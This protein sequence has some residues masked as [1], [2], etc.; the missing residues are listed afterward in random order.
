M[1]GHPCR[2]SSD[3]DDALP[4]IL[5]LASDHQ[6]S[7]VI[8]QTL[9]EA[10][11]SV[12]ST[13][14]FQR[15]AGGALVQ[16]GVQSA[17]T[18]EFTGLY[19]K[20]TDQGLHPLVVKGAVIRELYPRGSLRPSIDEDLL[21]REEEAEACSA[22]LV[23]EGFSQVLPEQ[24]FRTS[25]EI[26]YEN[27]ERHLY[28]EVHK[29]LFP[30]E[31]SAYGRLNALFDHV[32]D[33]T[34]V[35]PV[36][37]VSLYTLGADDHLLYLIFHAYKHFLYSGVGIRP[38]CDIG[39]YA[40][41]YEK[42]I[43]WTRLR[44]CLEKAHAFVFACALFR[45]IELYLLRDAAFF[46]NLT[47]WKLEEQDPVPLLQDILDGGLHGSATLVR[48]HSAGITLKAVEN[49]RQ[50]KNIKS[51]C[52]PLFSSGQIPYRQISLSDQE[53]DPAPLCMGTASASLCRG[54][55]KQFR[56]RNC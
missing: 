30:E 46:R 4:A 32:W 31:S 35:Q 51:P 2:L 26:S 42:Q 25:S 56:Y 48:R 41:R 49:D 28:L 6:I 44:D 54:S 29:T 8:C 47:E 39:L 15:A 36:N 37:R 38:L 3:A 40:E 7:P 50:G 5:A 12:C 55:K 10:A 22:L 13:A 43:N 53:S 21:I 18:A 33:N 16:A 24:S 23:R 1:K 11:D 45:I 19:R 20:M 27:R 17:A 9:Y 14:V 34:E 52:C